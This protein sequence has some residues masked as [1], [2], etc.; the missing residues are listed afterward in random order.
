MPS[1]SSRQSDASSAM[2]AK[3]KLLLGCAL[4]AELDDAI[5]HLA[6]SLELVQ[7]AQAIH[8][9]NVADAHFNLALALRAR[10]KY[11][12][13]IEHL[14]RVLDIRPNDREAEYNL[15]DILESQRRLKENVEPGP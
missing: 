11:Q 2:S 14:R 3:L 8:P 15:W 5:S 10:G 6:R 9:Y 13:A 1:K 7:T 12:D 4:I